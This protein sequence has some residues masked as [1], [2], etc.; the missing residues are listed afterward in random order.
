MEK[1]D[2]N[3][4][5]DALE[6]KIWEFTR[7]EEPFPNPNAGDQDE[8]IVMTSQFESFICPISQL[9]IDSAKPYTSKVCGHTFSSVS[10]AF[11]DDL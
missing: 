4:Y 3:Q 7:P 9:P 8:D 11:A 1:Y 10:C 2:N 5:Y 6:R